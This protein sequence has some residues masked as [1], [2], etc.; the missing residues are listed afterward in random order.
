V[1]DFTRSTKVERETVLNALDCYQRQP[2]RAARQHDNHAIRSNAV[3]RLH[4]I[5]TVRELVVSA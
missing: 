1:I 5:E 3:W 2:A 4:V